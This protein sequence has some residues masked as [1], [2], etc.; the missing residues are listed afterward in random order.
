MSRLRA[1][2]TR[3]ALAVGVTLLGTV[4]LPAVT[5][6]GASATATTLHVD[7]APGANCSDAAGV[8]SAAPSHAD[9]NAVRDCWTR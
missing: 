5:A 3:T 7:H 4:G 9:R 1:S 6:G 8:G 2:R